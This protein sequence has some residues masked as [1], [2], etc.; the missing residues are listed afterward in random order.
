MW[1]MLEDMQFRLIHNLQ[2]SMDIS[3]RQYKHVVFKQA[4]FGLYI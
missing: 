2:S 4:K 3:F 1:L